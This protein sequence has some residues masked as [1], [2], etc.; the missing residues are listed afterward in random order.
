MT[1]VASKR[2]AKNT[3]L[4]YIRTALTMII[5][6]YTSRVVLQ[7]L[8]F[9]DYGIYN[10]VGG[11][12]AIL[13]CFTGALTKTTL[14]Y[15]SFANGEGNLENS[16]RVYTVALIIHV[17]L[18]AV[19]LLIGYSLA[20][21]FISKLNIPPGRE[22]EAIIVFQLSIWV[23][24]INLVRIIY[25]SLIVSN[26][27]LSFYAIVGILDAI[28]KLFIAILISQADSDR[29]ILYCQLLVVGNAVTLVLSYFYCKIKYTESKLSRHFEISQFKSFSGFAGWSFMGG[30][31]DLVSQSAFSIFSNLRFGVIANAAIG[32]M[33]QVQSAV[34]KF[35][36]SFSMS[37]NPQIIK[38]YAGGENDRL[39]TLINETSKISLILISFFT[40]PILF[41]LGLILRLWLGD[42][43]Q[44]TIEF[45]IIA[46]LCCILDAFTSPYN[47]AITA[48]GNIKRYQIA[49]TVSYFLDAI[50]SFS[51]MFVVPNPAY[52]F[53]SRFFTRGLFNMLIGLHFMR[54]QISFDLKK[55][56]KKVMSPLLYYIV[57]LVVIYCPTL[58]L[59]ESIRLII[60]VIYIPIMAL[61]SY[62]YLLIEDEK[63]L[64]RTMIKR[65]IHK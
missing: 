53:I 60:S 12:V 16:R 52:A 37:Y 47:T 57:F 21:I 32:V 29:L 24:V 2:M 62:K 36:S 56:W 28:I 35:I 5:A 51:L 63:I 50:I 40:V 38:A 33:N 64:V 49:L 22:N 15:F 18:C 61:Y 20:S 13:S 4:M 23:F 30:S 42:I 46:L 9:E 14:R 55:Y 59:N 26:E 17:V 34:N 48:T 43:P 1:G 6:L 25:D 41:N 7:S 65:V 8:G 45:C 58:L 19:V 31:A 27:S 10:L 11:I 39:D 3:V 54:K 44:Y